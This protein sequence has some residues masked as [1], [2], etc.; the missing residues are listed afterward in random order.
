MSQARAIEALLNK[1]P[2]ESQGTRNNPRPE[3][4][5]QT[6]ALISSQVDMFSNQKLH[7]PLS[8]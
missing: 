4:P 8:E 1:R 6:E 7:E 5:V 3:E 2:D